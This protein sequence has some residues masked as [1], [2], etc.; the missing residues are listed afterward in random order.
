MFGFFKV[1]LL[2]FV[3]IPLSL[4]NCD[5]G[6]GT[7]YYNVRAADARVWALTHQL[8]D[9]Q[10]ERVLDTYASLYF[11]NQ[12]QHFPLNSHGTCS[13]VAIS[14]LL[15]FWDSYCD[16]WFVDEKYEEVATF[17]TTSSS[18]QILDIPSFDVES[19]GLKGESY[20]QVW[21]MS[22]SAYL[23]F[24]NKHDDEYLQCHLINMACS[25]FG[26]ARFESSNNPYGF[27]LYEQTSL[28][29][30]YLSYERGITNRDAVLSVMEN[31]NIEDL[32]EFVVGKVT[33]GSPVILNLYTKYG[34]HAVVAYDY[35]SKRDELYVHPGWRVPGSTALTH[36]SLG[37]IGS[38]FAKIDGAIA[39]EP[40][41]TPLGETPNYRS[42]I[43]QYCYSRRLIYP[44]NIRA[45]GRL[46]WDLE[47]TFKWD[48]LKD[49]WREYGENRAFKVQF[50]GP[51]YEVLQTF[52]RH[53]SDQLTIGF[54]DWDH[55]LTRCHRCG[56]YIR[57]RI[58][59]D[60]SGIE[61]NYCIHH[62]DDPQ[63]IFTDEP[64]VVNP[65]NYSGYD[66]SFSSS[67]YD[68]STFVNHR[69]E[70]GFLFKTRWM[71]AGRFDESL[72]LSCKGPA[73]REAFVEYQFI[74]PV[75]RVDVDISAFGDITAEGLNANAASAVIE[76]YRFDE[77]ESPIL[78]FLAPNSQLPNGGAGKKTYTLS[79]D[80]P[81]TRFRIH[82]T[83]NAFSADGGN[84]G[85]ICIGTMRIYENPDYGRFVDHEYVDIIPNG[86]EPAYDPEPWNSEDV[87]T[88][89]N[90]YTYALN[91]LFE[92]G[93]PREP[94]FST[95]YECRFSGNPDSFESF[96]N[97][98]GFFYLVR[99]DSMP[100]AL[101][102]TNYVFNETV[103]EGVP[104]K[105]GFIFDEAFK[106]QTTS[107]GSYRV[108][109]AFDLKYPEKDYHWFRQGP[110]GF[111][112][113]KNGRLGPV[114][115]FDFDGNPICDPTYCN[116][117]LGDSVDDM[118]NMETSSHFYSSDVSFFTIKWNTEEVVYEEGYLDTG[119]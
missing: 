38:S 81:I 116:R 27:S 84:S 32:K 87:L 97:V 36:V 46:S 19:P 93:M 6:E 113:G 50:L 98:K 16:D 22:T 8:G 18:N 111:W 20:G 77:Y 2:A 92:Y 114:A 4:R 105:Y 58:M 28:L 14:Q 94:G 109:L 1:L 60:S 76:V 65:S 79:F 72:V 31:Y 103:S 44:R 41:M 80:R 37:Q 89:N 75:L 5:S 43:G 82:A 96:F 85:R 62:F 86:S 64:I 9:K 101:S 68:G 29:N 47:P 34:Y 100:G 83:S 119:C 42:S 118:R 23:D 35:D 112:S 104:S 45:A 73:S 71:R 107:P 30:R 102:Y 48:S 70:N 25:L 7:H 11:Y 78:D 59:S 10:G 90:C 49:E 95:P 40:R 115:D 12:R 117:H 24:A 57:V 99:N 106:T 88:C 52:D 61:N 66:A 17:E 69:L 51:N 56:F 74:V 91:A 26:D 3:T 67:D 33:S 21:R 108:A 39:I 13:Y 55:L 53:N 54:Q 63:R 15:S 110:D